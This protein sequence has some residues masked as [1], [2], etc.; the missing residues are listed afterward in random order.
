MLGY[1][2]WVDRKWYKK[3]SKRTEN[4]MGRIPGS[5]LFGWW[6]Y[7]NALCFGIRRGVPRPP[8]MFVYYPTAHVGRRVSMQTV[9]ACVSYFIPGELIAWLCMYTQEEYQVA[10]KR[11]RFIQFPKRNIL[12]ILRDRV[13]VTGLL[14][15][16]QASQQSL[17]LRQ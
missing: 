17:E 3:V 14:T 1:G 2:S 10:A 9:N 15:I 12:F 4:V 7:G 13:M 6:H 5:D 16:P 8:G 11:R